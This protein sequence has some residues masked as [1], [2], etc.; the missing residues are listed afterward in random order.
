MYCTYTK[1][2]INA[3]TKGIRTAVQ[4]VFEVDRWIRHGGRSA[5]MR[6]RL[7]EEGLYV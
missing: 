6:P 1:Q 5:E 7:W 4:E 2:V 3:H